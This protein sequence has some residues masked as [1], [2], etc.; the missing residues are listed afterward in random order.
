MFNSVKTLAHEKDIVFV[1]GILRFFPTQD[2][3]RALTQAA[4]TIKAPSLGAP[5][6]KTRGF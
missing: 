3:R 4:R 5:P 6:E 2:N 1:E